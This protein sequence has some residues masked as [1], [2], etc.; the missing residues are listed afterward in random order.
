MCCHGRVYCALGVEPTWCAPYI[1]QVTACSSTIQHHL[2][3]KARF[4]AAADWLSDAYG[5]RERAGRCSR[6]QEGLLRDL[7]K[8]GDQ[9]AVR[10]ATDTHDEGVS[11][12]AHGMCVKGGVRVPLL[13]YV[14]P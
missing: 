6:L 8:L 12:H 9:A 13:G 14:R 2:Q 7:L 1:V 10:A 4:V 3:S 5:N 11:T